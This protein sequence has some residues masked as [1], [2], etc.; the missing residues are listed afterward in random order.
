[1]GLD[2]YL[3]AK[4]YISE[5]NPSDADLRA[6]IMAM[7]FGMKDMEVKEV[8]FEAMYWRKA[9]AIHNWFVNNVQDGVDNCAEYYVSPDQL[10]ELR[11]I[12]KSVLEDPEKAM[13]LLPPKAG[14]FFGSTDID[15]YFIQDLTDTVERFDYLLELP[16]VK[17]HNINFYYCSSW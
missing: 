5:Y 17:E 7:D 14:F 16:D 2:M 4:R 12:C 3:T 9:N 11:D 13:Q 6:G 15:E 1:M 10:T 8:S